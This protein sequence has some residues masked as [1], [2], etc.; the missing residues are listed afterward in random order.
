VE[1][2]ENEVDIK[3]WVAPESKSTLASLPNNKTC[4]YF[5]RGPGL[6]LRNSKNPSTIGCPAAGALCSP[7]G[8]SRPTRA[9]CSLAG[10]PRSTTGTSRSTTGTS[11]SS[12]DV[13]YLGVSEAAEQKQ[14]LRFAPA[15]TKTPLGLLG[16]D[17]WN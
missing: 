8:A 1:C 17:N 6:L 16:V 15:P 10:T 4:D 5:Q 14:Y 7:A 3:D 11:C 2:S 13:C 9:L 12:D